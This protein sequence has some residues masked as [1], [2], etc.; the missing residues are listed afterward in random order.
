MTN[1]ELAK[2]ISAHLQR[3]EN[4]LEINTPLRAGGPR[5]FYLSGAYCPVGGRLIRLVYVSYQGACR[6]TPEA[7][8]EYLSWLDSGGV[9]THWDK[10]RKERNR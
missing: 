4:D 6:V 9:G 2:Q 1:Q 8:K 3:F 10:E 7:A 5:R